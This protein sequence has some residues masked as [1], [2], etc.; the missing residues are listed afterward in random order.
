VDAEIAAKYPF[1]DVSR[2][3]FVTWHNKNGHE[4]RPQFSMCADMEERRSGHTYLDMSHIS[5]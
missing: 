1:R 2:R 5:L 3:G 4:A